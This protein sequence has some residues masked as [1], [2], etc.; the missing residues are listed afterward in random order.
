MAKLQNKNIILG[1]CGSISAYKTPNL[2]R[3]F[4]KNNFDVQCVITESAKK[5]V[6]ELTLS[7]LSKN[8]VI[9]ELFD[10]EYSDDGAWHVK[11]AHSVDLCL[12]APCSATTLSKIANGLCDNALTTLVCALPKNIPVVIYPAMDF[13][14]W[15]NPA[16]IDNVKK[17]R[18]YGYHVIEPETGELSSGLVGKGRLHNEESIVSHVNNMLTKEILN[19]INENNKLINKKCLITLGPT[20][21]KIDQVRYLSNFSS[22]KMGLELAKEA[23]ARG[24]EVTIVNGPVN[25][26]LNGFNNFPIKSADEMYDKIMEIKENYDLIIM[27]AAVADYKIEKPYD[28]KIKKEGNEN[29]TLDLVKNKDILKSLGQS[30]GKNQIIVGFALETENEKHNALKKI[31]EKNVDL[32]VLNSLN[33]ENNVFGNDNNKISIIT[34]NSTKDFD[35]MNKSECARVII[36]ELSEFI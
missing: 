5:F 36:N 29:I 1:I 14:M 2:V 23:K 16:V 22:G 30:K 12:I 8:K 11:L 9:S 15:E 19:N 24:M 13:T 31:N 6:S 34:K 10:K 3:L 25:I 33:S 7:N 26:D 32:I 4:K 21:E 27:S 20:I 17:L 18:Q 28:G 35:K